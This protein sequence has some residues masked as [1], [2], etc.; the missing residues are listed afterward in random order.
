[1]LRYALRDEVIRNE[2][3]SI[4]SEAAGLKSRR[5]RTQVEL[6]KLREEILSVISSL[7]GEDLLAF[8]D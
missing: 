6:L 5:D 2:D 3:S 4:Q 7:T 1:M 8:L